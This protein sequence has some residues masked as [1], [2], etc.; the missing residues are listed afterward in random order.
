MSAGDYRGRRVL[1]VGLARSGM[2]AVKFLL[3]QGAL[4]RAT[5]RKTEKELSGKASLL[6]EQGVELVLGSHP[7]ELVAHVDL[8]VVS[9]GV[10]L[11]QP[12]FQEAQAGGIPIWGEL[13]LGFREIKGTVIAVTGTKGKS[14]T[15]TLVEEI[16]KRADRPVLLG[17]NIGQPLI[18]LV[19]YSGPDSLV[20]VEVS[21]FQLECAPSFRPHIAV[22]LNIT[23]DHLDRHSS[24]DS[25]VE[26]K[27]RIFANQEEGDWAVV[28]AGDPLT[29][30]M[31]VKSRSRKVYF[32]TD[33]LGDQD[34]HLCVQGP[35]I[36]KHEGGETTALL[37][38]DSIPLCGRHLVEDIMAASAV[39]QILD[40]D[41]KVVDETVTGFKGIPHE[42]GSGAG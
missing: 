35:W 3:R 15:V 23:S 10:P 16:L 27:K 9:P 6:R 37:S 13:E 8:V 1:V 36:V 39:S 33:C 30:E 26:T 22:L 18:G 34:S 14:T 5:D 42:R 24:F 41:A 20:V 7:R 29:V 25:Y 4:V 31:A 19:E 21:S 12:L 17:G 32:S 2:A 40:I 11:E 38:L 28:F